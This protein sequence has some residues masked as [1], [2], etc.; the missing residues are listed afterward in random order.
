MI[1][2]AILTIS[3]SCF[4]GQRE[5]LSGEAIKKILKDNGYTV[6]KK[7]IVADE[8]HAIEAELVKFLEGDDCD[9]VF[10][11]GGTGLGPRDVTP[12]AT[13][14]VCDKLV[15]GLAE[16]MRLRGFE[17]TPNAVLS[18]AVVGIR[19][20]ALIVNLPGST[21]AV[22]ESLE[23]VLGLLPHA[24]EMIQGGGH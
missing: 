23:V 12:E 9:I 1:K 13:T 15:P 7:E 22:R 17:K 20:T 3:D 10:T 24:I 2:A 6:F 16:L 4:K 21:R 5:D 11:T 18:R 8:T 14:A 19:G